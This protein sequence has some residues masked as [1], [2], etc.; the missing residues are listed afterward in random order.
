MAPPPQTDKGHSSFASGFFGCFGVLAAIVVAIVVLIVIGSAASKKTS[1][2]P[3]APSSAV[4]Q[5]PP[6]D[7]AVN[8]PPSDKL[9]LLSSKCTSDSIGYTT[10][11]GFVKNISS[12]NLKS[13]EVVISWYDAAGVPQSTSTGFVKFDPLLVGQESGWKTFDKDNPALKTYRVQFKEF[14]GATVSYRD[15]RVK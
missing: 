15:D 10:C 12:Q 8:A 4:G 14:L 9:A 11:E 3:N 1:N 6:N 2:S 5:P 13:L 7:A